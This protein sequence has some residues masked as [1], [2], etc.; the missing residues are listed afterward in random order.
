MK[1]NRQ[2]NRL[3]AIAII[4]LFLTGLSCKKQ[5]METKEERTILA[6]VNGEAITLKDLEMEKFFMFFTQIQSI[7]SPEAIKNINKNLLGKII[8]K[9]ILLQEARREKIT[10]SKEELEKEIARIRSDYPDDTFLKFFKEN[11]ISYEDWKNNM[12]EL[13]IIQKLLDYKAVTN[14]VVS[15]EEIY[16]YYKSHIDDF[17]NINKILLRQI[18]VQDAKTAEEVKKRLKAGENFEKLASEFSISYEKKN[19]GLLPLLSINELPEELEDV[20]KLNIGEIFGPV[21]TDYG[22][23]IVRVEKKL[24]RKKIELKDAKNTIIEILKREK[25]NNSLKEYLTNLRKNA[26]IEIFPSEVLDT[27]KT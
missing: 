18:L 5:D 7:A 10:I 26:R 13:M 24:I 27:G 3:L 21:K 9:K 12:V 14:P 2:I 8:D 15:E 4:T 20:F 6:R 23:H 16:L 17:K 11:A 22:Y 1:N 19:G 25:I